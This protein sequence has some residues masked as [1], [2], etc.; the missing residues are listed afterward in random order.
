MAVSRA[1]RRGE[2]E[3]RVAAVFGKYR[4]ARALDLLELVELAWHDCYGE[5]T[6]PEEIIDDMLLLSDGSME[7]LIRDA[8]LAVTDSRD[9]KVAA[10]APAEPPVTAARR[11]GIRS[12]RSAGRGRLERTIWRAVVTVV[13]CRRRSA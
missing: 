6:P 13:W 8:H 4:A 9:L 5:I 2:S 3:R 10:N 1:G 7:G 12:W 11:G